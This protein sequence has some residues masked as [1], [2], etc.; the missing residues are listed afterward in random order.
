VEA[1]PFLVDALLGAMDVAEPFCL[2]QLLFR[3]GFSPGFFGGIFGDGDRRLWL[4]DGLIR[5]DAVKC[6]ILDGKRPKKTLER[7]AEKGPRGGLKKM[8]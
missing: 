4:K 7:R 3:G 6:F 8:L 2:G 5:R 1:S